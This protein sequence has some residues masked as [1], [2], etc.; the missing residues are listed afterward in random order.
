MSVVKYSMVMETLSSSAFSI[1]WGMLSGHCAISPGRRSMHWAYS[2]YQSSYL[3]P[4]SL[5]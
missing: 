1:R 2:S 4:V 3:M 5:L